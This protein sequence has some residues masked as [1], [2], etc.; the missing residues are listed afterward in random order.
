MIPKKRRKRAPGAGRPVGT[1]KYGK[2]TLTM[3][4]PV[5]MVKELQQYLGTEGFVLPLYTAPVQA[6]LPS[7]ADDDYEPEKINLFHHLVPRPESSYFVMVRGKSMIG[8]G[9]MPGDMLVVDKSMEPRDGSIVIASLDGEFTVKRFKHIKGKPYL[10][11][12]NSE[13]DPIPI[14][15]HHNAFLHGVVTSCIHTVK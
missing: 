3:R 7:M 9:I 8:A 4:V 14:L 11:P 12:E 15:P 1:G 6:G 5:H 10:M 2:P 13:F